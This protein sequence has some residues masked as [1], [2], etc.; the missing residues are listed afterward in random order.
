MNHI[1]P[2][3]NERSTSR[4]YTPCWFSP[5]TVPNQPMNMYTTS[6]KPGSSTQPDSAGSQW[7][8]SATAPNNSVKNDAEAMIGQWLEWGT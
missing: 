4:P 3:R 6:A 5:M 7:L 8:S 2:M 1:I